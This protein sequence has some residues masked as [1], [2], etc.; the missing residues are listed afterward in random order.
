MTVGTSRRAERIAAFEVMDV[1]RQARERDAHH[2]GRATCH[3]EVGQPG[4]PA[5]RAV[6][7]AAREA[8]ERPLGYTDGLGTP[9]L[10]ARIAEHYH[11]RHGIDLDPERVAV[12]TG[13]SGGCVLA[14][15]AF[16][17]VG[18]RV[19]VVQPGYPCYANI[20]EA[21][22]VEAVAVPVGT[23]TGYRPTPGALD[24]VGPLT[25][26]VV[27]NP[28]N[29]TGAV[30]DAAEL[31]ALATW[32]QDHGARLVLDEIYHGIADRPLPTAA[33]RTD[34]VVVQSFSKYFCMTGWR[35]GWLVLP[36]AAVR[37][38]ERLAQNLFLAPP[39]ISQLAAVAAFDATEELDLH[40]RRHRTN[41][42][43][44]VEMLEGVGVGDI[45]PAEGAF[46]VWADLSEWGSSRALCR[47]WLEELGV[48]ATPGID[49][50]PARGERYVRFSVAGATE[51]VEDAADRLGPW[52]HEHR[53]DRPGSG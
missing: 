1:V 10:R 18:D 33:A 22:G 47:R 43:I 5:P 7:D 14:F 13:A 36:D 2:D 8:L 3:L 35:L 20:L 12:T 32:C 9:E 27:A 21:L 52:L 48:A 19:G 46:Y 39:T 29:P 34:A 23:D 15:L 17:D 30:L 41:R 40:A 28:S 42:R 16:F 25:G 51:E 37:A 6:I 11:R 49:F 4:R 24:A 38:V 50:D 31:D 45:A 44:L 26:V 53:H